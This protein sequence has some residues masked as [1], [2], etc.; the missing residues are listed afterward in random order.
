M[1]VKAIG[2][3]ALLLA[4]A[5]LLLSLNFVTPWDEI[6]LGE[7]AMR[8]WDAAAAV[9]HFTAAIH[10]KP[11]SPEVRLRIGSDYAD[12]VRFYGE[13]TPEIMAMADAAIQHLSAVLALDNR[14]AKAYLKLGAVFEWQGRWNDAL[15]SY[16]RAA[17]LNPSDPLPYFR[18]AVLDWFLAY[19]RRVQ[20]LATHGLGWKNAFPT[21]AECEQ[22][23]RENTQTINNGIAMLKRAL[24]L[25]PDEIDPLA[26]LRALYREK[27]AASCGDVAARATALEAAEKWHGAYCDKRQ[28]HE[29]SSHEYLSDGPAG[30]LGS[31]CERESPSKK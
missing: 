8:R 29:F 1:P 11:E 30:L 22:V 15:R 31:P 24:Q 2:G 18:I 5:G 9:A 27:A 3:I 6:A 12:A 20:V 25:A 21:M 19:N 10:M 28:Q 16:D 23:S 7:D 17:A 14:N 13:V 4:L 26:Y